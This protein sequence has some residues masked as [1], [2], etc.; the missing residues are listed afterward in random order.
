MTSGGPIEAIDG[1]HEVDLLVVGS[2]AGGMTAALTAAIDGLDVLV[3]E[4]APVY[5][6]TTAIS[7]GGIWVPNNPTLERAGITDPE[8]R[9]VEYLEHITAGKVGRE[10]LEAYVHHGPEMFRMFE[11]SAP[12]LRFS[13]CP[14]YS[15][16]HPEAPGGRPEGRSVECPPFDMRALGD[17]AASQRGSAMKVPG[18]LIITSADYVHL[19]MVTRTWRGRWRALKLGVRSNLNRLRRRHMV[20]LGPTATDDR[21][22]AG[23]PLPLGNSQLFRMGVSKINGRIKPRRRPHRTPSQHARVSLRR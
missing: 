21:Q 9:V 12:H 13:W 3:V 18:G 15:D 23:I 17:L 19:N 20:S 7:G 1:T 22:D 16:Y 6:G 10:R 11:R 14:G 2:G 4:K 8:S 5:G